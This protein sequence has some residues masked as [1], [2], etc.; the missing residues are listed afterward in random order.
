MSEKMF[1]VVKTDSQ[2]LSYVLSIHGT[3]EESIASLVKY[4]D[5]EFT[6]G[7]RVTKKSGTLFEVHQNGYLGKYFIAKF[8]ILE[9]EKPI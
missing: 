4:I 9:C 1:I 8:Q 2:Y 6:Q 5:D 3:Y 7:F